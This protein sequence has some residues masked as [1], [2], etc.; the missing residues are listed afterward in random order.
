VDLA[1]ITFQGVPGARLAPFRL[2]VRTVETGC[3]KRFTLGPPL[4][5]IPAVS[6]PFPSSSS[7][8][9]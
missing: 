2:T 4:S 5:P 6:Y 3:L 7:G 1:F 8:M 9:F